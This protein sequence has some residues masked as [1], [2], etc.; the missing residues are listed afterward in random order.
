MATIAIKGHSTKGKEIIELL[1]MLGGKNEFEDISFI[2]PNI[3]LYIDD[4]YYSEIEWD[5]IGLEEIEK[6][7]IFTLEEFLEKYPYK[8]GDKVIVGYYKGVWEIIELLWSENLNIIHYGISNGKTKE[9]VRVEEIKPYKEQETTEEPKELL[10]GFIKD[11][12]DDWILNTHKDYEIKEVNGKFKLIKKKPKYPKE[13][14]ECCEILN[15]NPFINNVSGYAQGLIGAF[16][17]L[18]TCYDAYRKIAGEQMGLDKPWE[19]NFDNEYYLI[20]NE[21]GEIFKYNK[22]AGRNAILTFPTEE[23]RDDFYENFKGLIE[24][25]KKVL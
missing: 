11:N 17:T 12:E 24:Q 23:M 15:H 10:I 7:K 20:G 19:P 21:C 22:I 18:I 4:D 1:K 16:Q 5:Y 6:Y 3:F 25:C 13:Y 9:L 14:L 2:T 8:V